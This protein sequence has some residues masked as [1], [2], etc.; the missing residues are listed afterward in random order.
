MKQV[1]SQL[2]SRAIALALNSLS[3]VFR[4]PVGQSI[5]TSFP[6]VMANPGMISLAPL[7]HISG[8]DEEGSFDD[9]G[10]DN[11]VAADT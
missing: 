10:G 9:S 5:A 6:P 2:G 11:S 4:V 7:E 8:A 3:K 1:S